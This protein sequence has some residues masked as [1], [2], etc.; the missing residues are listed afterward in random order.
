[1][2]K[3]IVAL[4]LQWVLFFVV[5]L[6]KLG[7]GDP[8]KVPVVY[9]QLLVVCFVYLGLCL[10]GIVRGFAAHRLWHVALIFFSAIL[11]G[12]LLPLVL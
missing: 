12:C 8:E 4:V 3:M 5:A 10:F 11:H 9:E 2:R 1:M 7:S 6:T